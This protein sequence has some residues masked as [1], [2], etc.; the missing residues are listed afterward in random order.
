MG[1]TFEEL[2]E[3]RRAADQAHSRV[4]ELRQSFGPPTEHKW[5]RQ[6]TATYETAWRAWRDL[7]RDLR[8]AMA[9][10]AKEQGRPRQEVEKE[11]QTTVRRTDARG[12]A[13]P[14]Q[15]RE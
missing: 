3:K 9:E 5:T 12:R 11:V 13:E 14:K 1:H 8:S 7:D 6:Q 4:D 15:E 10:Y 2:V